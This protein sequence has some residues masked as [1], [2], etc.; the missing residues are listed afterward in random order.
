MKRLSIYIKEALKPEINKWIEGVYKSMTT[1]VKEK[2]LDMISITN[3]DNLGCPEKSFPF[4]DF[5]DS[6]IVRKI[7]DNNKFGF[8]VL[9]QMIKMPD[10]YIALKDDKNSENLNPEVLPY[11]YRPEDQ[12]DK[13]RTYYVA[14]I[15][16]DTNVKYIEDCAHV[17]A[18]EAALCV[19]D[20]DKFL[21][22][23]FKLFALHYLNK[24]GS[25]KGITAKPLHPKMKAIL[26]KI[27][28]KPYQEN[29]EI[30]VY[31]I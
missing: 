1:L 26:S 6:Q 10:K 23:L 30:F 2:T 21:K 12:N 15:V 27:G 24:K 5:V 19:D 13:N 9:S 3:F 25:F 28:F 20:S 16:F 7:I 11:W 22:E 17:I 8:T 4:T 18:V 29:K 14:T 31:K